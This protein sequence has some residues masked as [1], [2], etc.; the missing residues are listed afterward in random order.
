MSAKEIKALVDIA[1]TM[2]YSGVE[3]KQFVQMKG[4]EWIRKKN[5]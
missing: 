2:G 1:T 5:R 4:W 3:L